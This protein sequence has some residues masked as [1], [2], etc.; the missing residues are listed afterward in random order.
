MEKIQIHYKKSEL[1]K[2]FFYSLLFV[3]LGVWL[4]SNQSDFL[5]NLPKFDS[6]IGKTILGI[7]TAILGIFG[8]VYLIKC[9]FSNNPAIIIDEYGILNNSSAFPK[10]HINWN[11]IQNFEITTIGLS[12]IS[13]NVVRINHKNQNNSPIDISAGALN[14]SN[15][16][17]LQIFEQQFEIHTV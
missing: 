5:L 2:R 15:R 16:E 7:V 13:L 8:I 14:I 4:I 1:I 6:S 17:L 11:E 3:I 12:S 9:Y 10:K